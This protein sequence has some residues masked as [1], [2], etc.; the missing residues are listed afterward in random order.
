M[1]KDKKDK[2]FNQIF[3]NKKT[4]GAIVFVI[5]ILVYFLFLWISPIPQPSGDAPEYLTLARNVANGNGFS[6]DGKIPASYRPPLF[7]HLL[8]L[9]FKVTNTETVL[10]AVF[11]QAILQ[12]F[13]VLLTFLLLFEV[14]SSVQ[15]A[16]WGGLFVSLNP[17]LFT[18]IVFV[19]QESTLFF[20]TTLAVFLTIRWLKI[21]TY[22]KA[23]L[24]GFGWGLATLAKIVTWYVPLLLWGMWIT[25]KI[26]KKLNWNLLWKQI[27]LLI[28]VFIFTVGSW[29]VRNYI[30]FKKFIL[31]NDQ[32]VKA[33][34]WEVKAGI[35]HNFGGREYVQ[36]LK[37]QKLPEKEYKKKLWS[38]IFQHHKFFILQEIK[39]FLSF[40]QFSREW[41]GH[42]VGL[43]M[44]WY[45]WIVPV[46]FIQFPL[47]IGF[48]ISLFKKRMIISFMSIF[49]L[50]YW[51]EYTVIWG[52][53]R[54]AV[55]VYPVLVALGLNGLQYL[56]AKK[57]KVVDGCLTD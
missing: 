43:S 9:W 21:Q 22:K 34:E 37:K 38:Y 17:F 26:F 24:A 8:G 56:T 46:I 28:T 31:L 41:F 54:Y 11:F 53:P 12:S 39:N 25:S 6:Y 18:P 1:I 16:F 20:V 51:L 47:Y 49:Y 30:H 45:I 2:M 57:K 48:F 3:K 36:E 23:F 55:P 44:R 32:G 15:I 42:V 10:S 40:T 7:S 27:L 14:F 4:A 52:I 33:L 13:G 5:S 19:L 29:T 35:L 50:I